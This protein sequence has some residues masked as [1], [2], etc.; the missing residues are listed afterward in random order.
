MWGL[1]LALAC[2][3]TPSQVRQPPD[4]TATTAGTPTTA[5]TGA[6]GS[7]PLAAVGHERELRGVWVASV[8][9][10]NYPSAQGLS[11]EALE[12]ELDALVD[13]CA[14]VGVNAIFF[15]VRP[16]A[17][18]LYESALE[19]W[20]RFLTG[21]QGADPGI[22][23]LAI[24]VSLAHARAIQVH[25]WLNPYRAKASASSTAV[26]PHIS[27]AY[28]EY[29]HPYNGLLWMDPGA[30]AVRDWTVD[31]LA[32]LATRYA[33]DGI[34]FD[35]YFYPYPDGTDFP[36]DATYAAYGGGAAL[37]DWRRQNVN[38]LLADGKAAIEAVAPWVAF[39][40]A[41]F[42]IY[43]PGQPEGIVGLDQYAEIYADPLAWLDEGSVDYLGPQLY[44]A[45]DDAGQEFEP[46]VGWWAEQAAG[47]AHTFPGINLDAVDDWGADEIGAQIALVRAQRAQGARGIILW[48][49]A[50]LE[51]DRAGVRSR[52]A[53]EWFAEPALPP[54]L[55]DAPA[56]APPRV[57]VSGA[58]VAVTPVDPVPHFAWTVY[59]DTGGAWTLASIVPGDQ[60]RIALAP[61]R[62]AVAAVTRSG[63]E[64]PG[65]VIAIE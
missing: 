6:G 39:G 27:L 9:N 37:D 52:F 44:W 55:L 16:E 5:T 13:L 30:P 51:E 50:A 36:D 18:A 59:A 33:I 4:R 1:A 46:L 20:S 19:P 17:D 58:E 28:P 53:D 22:D 42:G 21:A 34:H 43:R 14:E 40:V 26:W 62:W 61:G 2:G 64:S 54:A 29:A 3:E 23:P 12:A 24:L 47:R 49:V 31:V 11:A 56:V 35:D 15:Q 41:P 10:I 48:N 7:L 32:D 45:T 57:T 8:W 65:V 38:R 63:A 60:G 25:A